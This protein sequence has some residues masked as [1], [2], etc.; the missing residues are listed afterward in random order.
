MLDGQEIPSKPYIAITEALRLYYDVFSADKT[1]FG[2]CC[3]RL[4][5]GTTLN[6]PA[7]TVEVVFHGQAHWD[8]VRHLR[9]GFEMTD[10]VGYLH[11]PHMAE[12]VAAFQALAKLEAAYCREQ[13]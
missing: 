12:L 2:F 13:T 8:G 5:N 9:V 4:C 7:C 1:G 3:V 10:N 11:Y 6:D